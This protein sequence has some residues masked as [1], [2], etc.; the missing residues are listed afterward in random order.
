MRNGSGEGTHDEER[1]QF[2][3]NRRRIEIGEGEFR[4]SPGFPLPLSL[5]NPLM[6]VAE[7]AETK[8]TTGY[9]SEVDSVLRT[10]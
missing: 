3:Q 5:E 6:A 7:F 10:P 8:L 9:R 1:R 4:E 2:G